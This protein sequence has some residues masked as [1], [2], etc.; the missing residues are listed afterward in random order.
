VATRKRPRG[1]ARYRGRSPRGQV[2][3]RWG[4]SLVSVTLVRP[5][6]GSDV[7]V[8]SLQGQ[9]RVLGPALIAYQAEAEHARIEVSCCIEVRWDSSKRTVMGTTQGCHSPSSRRGACRQKIGA[10][11]RS[12]ADDG[13]AGSDVGFRAVLLD[14]RNPLPQGDH[15][16]L[17]CSVTM[18]EHLNVTTFRVCSVSP[19]AR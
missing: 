9:V 1:G 18:V 17:H 14:W 2:P 3:L 11:R 12:S 5:R 10:S 8:V 15:H 4:P 7:D 19:F 6:S 13:T 16:R